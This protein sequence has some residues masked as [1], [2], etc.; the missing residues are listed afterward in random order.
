M[1]LVTD[2]DMCMTGFT[3]QTISLSVVEDTM[4]PSR[5]A[6]STPMTGRTRENSFDRLDTELG[7]F[8]YTN[9]EFQVTQVPLPLLS[10]LGVIATILIPIPI[11]QTAMHMIRRHDASR[12][13]II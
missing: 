3:N 12:H 5:S 7:D 8:S 11:K 1:L 10:F 13:I 4:S 6:E 9:P 2:N